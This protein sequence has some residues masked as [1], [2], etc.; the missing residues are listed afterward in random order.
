VPRIHR[1]RSASRHPRHADRAVSTTIALI[2]KVPALAPSR[3]AVD[4]GP[5]RVGGSATQ[6]LTV[7]NTRPAVNGP[8][9][10]IGIETGGDFSQTNDCPAEVQTA[11]TCTI[12]LTF[13]PR[14]AGAR[15]GTLS[16]SN[17]TDGATVTIPL[18]GTGTR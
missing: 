6:S 12:T 3:Y 17:R 18:K 16:I 11:G 10:V 15:V 2:V 1:R 8:V 9:E 4:F 5:Q 7:R 14:E 13:K